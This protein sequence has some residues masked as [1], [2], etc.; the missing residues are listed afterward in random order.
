[1]LKIL[2]IFSSLIILSSHAFA[3]ENKEDT[4]VLELGDTSKVLLLID[5]P[6][7]LQA[8]QAL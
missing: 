4:V 1:M 3:G 6:K 5:G 8:L 2:L 7:D